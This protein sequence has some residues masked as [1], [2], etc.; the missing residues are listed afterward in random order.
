[1]DQLEGDVDL[2]L[3]P[4]PKGVSD[5]EIASPRNVAPI[6]AIFFT[7]VHPS[8]PWT[9]KAFPCPF[10]S[11]ALLPFFSSSLLASLHSPAA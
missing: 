8:F 11:S 10:C 5:P 4:S 3:L 6:P 9:L 1:M 2:L 7:I